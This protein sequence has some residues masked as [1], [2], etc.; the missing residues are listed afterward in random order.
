MP[1][2]M[3]PSPGGITSLSASLAAQT[4]HRLL[5]HL[6]ADGCSH[7]DWEVPKSHRQPGVAIEP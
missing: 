2:R 7:H 4:A 3:W 5:E 6:G 1:A